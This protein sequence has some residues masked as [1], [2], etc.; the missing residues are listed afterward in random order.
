MWG[1]ND[2]G[3][4]NSILAFCNASLMV[5]SVYLYMARNSLGL[6]WL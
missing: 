6:V 3:V 5:L 1:V 4:G 2:G